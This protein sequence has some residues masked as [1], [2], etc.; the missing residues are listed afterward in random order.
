MAEF[1][2]SRPKAVN[3]FISGGG[4]GAK[5]DEDGVHLKYEL[6][7][8]SQESDEYRRGNGGRL[9]SSK[10]EAVETSMV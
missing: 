6:R 1:E 10:R 5:F 4:R 3:T 9:P 8:D 7:Q 2:M